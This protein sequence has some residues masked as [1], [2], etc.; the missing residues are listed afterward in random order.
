MRC[1]GTQ[2]VTAQHNRGDLICYAS[3]NTDFRDASDD[4]WDLVTWI[5]VN[6]TFW[7]LATVEVIAKTVRPVFVCFC[8]RFT[9]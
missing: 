5:V 7:I 2:L 3:S 8:R 6:R 9:V 1:R 4:I